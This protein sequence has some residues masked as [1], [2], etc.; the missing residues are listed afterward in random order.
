MASRPQISVIVPVR[1]GE[2]SLPALL[3]SLAGQSLPRHLFEVIV[4]DNGSSDNT[5]K[6]AVEHGARLLHEPLPNRARARNL[7]A[8]AA[9]P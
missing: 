3:A 6:I 8:S 4:V 5:A 2:R 7:G 9:L 1:N